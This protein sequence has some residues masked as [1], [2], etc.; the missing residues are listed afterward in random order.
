MAG[1]DKIT[2]KDVI[3]KSVAD[4]VNR[5]NKSLEQ[6]VKLM[7]QLTRLS[8]DA[9]KAFNPNNIQDV[10]KAVEDYN[11]VNEESQKTNKEAVT[12]L[13]KLQKK[14]KE[15]NEEEERAKIA[16]QEKR[17]AIRENIKAQK[18]QTSASVKLTRELQKEI[19]TENEAAR[20]NK[21]LIKIRKDVNGETAK[22]AKEIALINKKINNNNDLISKNSSNL[23]QQKIGIGKYKEGVTEALKEQDL[24][25]ISFN[26]LSSAFTSGAGVVGAVSAVILGLGKAY[27]S[28]ARGTEDMAR[29]SD[30]LQLI[31]KSLGNTLADVSGEAG[32][33]D[34]L[35]SGIQLKFQGLAKTLETNVQVAIL[36]TIRQLEI[37]EADQER[38]KKS[39]LDRAEVL[40]QIRDEERNS[41]EERKAANDELGEVINKRESETVAF[42]EKILTN[43]QTLLKFNEGDLELQRQIKQVEFEI[44]DAREEAQGFRS[45]QLAND[46]ALSKEYIANGLELQKT[47]LEGELQT[48]N[49]KFNIRKRLIDITKELELQAAGENQQLI[50]I[51]VQKAI[52]AEQELTRSIESEIAKRQESAILD[53]EKK[54]ENLEAEAEIEIEAFEEKLEREIEQEEQL[55]DAQ[56]ESINKVT[57]AQL[58]ADEA[59]KQ[60]TRDYINFATQQ[61]QQ[62]SNNIIG[63]LNQELANQQAAEIEKVKLKGGTEAEIEAIEKKFAKK[64]QQNAIIQATINTAIGVTQALAQ[65]GV[66]GIITGLLVAAAGAI[67][68]AT[69]SSQKFAKGTKDS[70]SEWIDAT[71]GEVGTEKVILSDGT[72]FFTPPTAT[73]MMLPPHSEVVPNHKLQRDLAEMQ[74][75]G[76]MIN[77]HY[78]ERLIKEFKEL[79]KVI[80]NKKETHFN[81]TEGGFHVASKQ[82]NVKFNY[83]QKNYRS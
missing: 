83:I 50:D 7:A 19:K 10:T 71:V 40:R 55:T 20:Q 66:L 82:G 45:E 27:A 74:T 51:A 35:I 36:S 2:Q 77:T 37:L 32:F 64:R 59:K 29:A 17:K 41:F 21:I 70:G 63:F 33:F 48:S 30:R 34:S 12:N 57:Q 76:R 79:K 46:L 39:Q 67:E 38:Q 49:D 58:A 60:S 62:L 4:E 42:Q 68:I 14:I 75:Q 47:I 11:K 22:G 78:D 31:T 8:T 15:V 65:G 25:G 69:I 13:E 23:E 28:S 61:A 53:L 73:K 18:D 72:S 5:L 81:L 44:A 56:I 24:F 16:L 1:K 43:L 54:A 26:K 3:E 6:S 52:N 9:F 80:K